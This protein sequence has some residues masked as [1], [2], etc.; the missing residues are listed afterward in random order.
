MQS[1]GLGKR[2]QVVRVGCQD[3]VAIARQAHD[4]SVDRIGPAASPQKHSRTFAEA[5]VQSFD[6]DSG[7][8]PSEYGLA[9]RPAAPNLR[10]DPPM[11]E[12]CPLRQAL[13]KGFATLAPYIV[14][15]RAATGALGGR[16]LVEFGGD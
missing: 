9:P 11:R 10:N 4:H 6:I 13:T 8:K 14:A 3:L 1:S 5:D 15:S 7:K 2:S 12:R 16:K